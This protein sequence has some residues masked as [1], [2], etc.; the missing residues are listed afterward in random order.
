MSSVEYT[1]AINETR[2][3]HE[4]YQMKLSFWNKFVVWSYTIGSGTMNTI[5]VTGTVDEESLR[6]WFER[7]VDTYIQVSDGL[8]ELPKSYEKFTPFFLKTSVASPQDQLEFITLF[9]RNLQKIIL[10]APATT[11]EITVYKASSPYPGLTVGNVYQRP[12]NSTSFRMDMNFSMF[13]PASGGCCMHKL[14]L[15]KGVNC[16]FISPLLSAYPYECEVLL[17]YGITFKVLYTSKVRLQTPLGKESTWNLLQK[18][19]ISLGPVYDY[20]YKNEC[21]RSVKEYKLFNSV[22]Y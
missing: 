9:S 7:V 20:N 12:F 2:L 22:V 19:N 13:L 5:L 14:E 15:Q 4:Q 8:V 16:L 18:G 17:P 6:I 21:S 3:L 10:S 11:G 1:R